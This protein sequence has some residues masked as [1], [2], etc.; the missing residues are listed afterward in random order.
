MIGY[1]YIFFFFAVIAEKIK[2]VSEYV[3][4]NVCII[5]T[6]LNS[7]RIIIIFFEVT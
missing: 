2:N 6:F 4:E 7:N 5:N 3:M 1:I